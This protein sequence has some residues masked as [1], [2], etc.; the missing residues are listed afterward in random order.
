VYEAVVAPVTTM[1]PTADAWSCG[2][3][4]LTTV[5]VTP[6]GLGIASGAVYS[7]ESLTVPDVAFPFVTP[8]TSHCTPVFAEVVTNT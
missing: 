5:T 1:V 2:F 6:S 4:T 7:P 3:A 8:F